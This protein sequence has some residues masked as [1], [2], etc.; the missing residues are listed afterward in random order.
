MNSLPCSLGNFAKLVVFLTVWMLLICET[1]SFS[2]VMLA[3]ETMFRKSLVPFQRK[4]NT[5]Y[6][7]QIRINLT[8][9]VK[10]SDGGPKKKKL[11]TN[12]LSK[13]PI[14]APLWTILAAAY[15]MTNPSSSEIFGTMNVMQN[16]LFA[17]MFAMGLAITPSDIVK[18]LSNPRILVVNALLCYGMVPSMALAMSKLVFFSAPNSTVV[19]LLLLSC[20]SGG[21]ASN[22]FTLI[23]G[24]DVA[25]SVICTLSTTLL[26]VIATPL[27]AKVLLGESVLVDVQGVFRSVAS[28]VL[29][30]LISGLSLGKLLSPK[31]M[32]VI[33]PILPTLGVFATLILVIGGA[34]N[35]M[36]GHISSTW[37]SV[38]LPS[39]LLC[40]G[41]GI[42]AWIL[43]EKL[44][45][46]AKETTKR[47]L[48][49]ETLS[50]SPTLAYVL[51]CRHFGH[52]SG[53]VPAAAMVT[54]AVLGALIASLW[55]TLDPI[56][57]IQ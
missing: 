27:L 34:S 4:N 54:L 52:S 13:F 33:S 18:V 43:I 31:T 17:L 37:T 23:A 44:M 53:T 24:G 12:L 46:G 7:R 22:L 40:L 30:P 3:R 21:Q 1:H 28:L 15:A 57:K 47:A 56:E 38:V 32:K 11:L 55:S 42:G 26:G 48:V 51:A 14:L 35:V 5:C 50:K 19:G 16:S 41:S 49:I 20:V 29:L 45:K 10:G 6:N 8:N 25:M 2:T 39:C 9:K 36:F